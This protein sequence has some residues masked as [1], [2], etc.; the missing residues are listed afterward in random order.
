MW[1]GWGPDLTF[2][3]NGGNDAP[4][5]EIRTRMVWVHEMKWCSRTGPAAHF[6]IDRAVDPVGQK[7][8]QDGGEHE[9]EER[10]H[11]PGG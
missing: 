8:V 4:A 3:Y 6:P 11:T 5:D 7:A 2:L 10:F 1:M 9:I